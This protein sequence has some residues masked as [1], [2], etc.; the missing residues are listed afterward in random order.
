MLEE[1][2]V[3]LTAPDTPIPYSLTYALCV[4]LDPVTKRI[5]LFWLDLLWRIKSPAYVVP[6]LPSPE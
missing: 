3:A 6:L 5:V 1:V 4:G 2:G